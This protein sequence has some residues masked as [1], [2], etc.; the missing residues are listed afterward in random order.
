MLTHFLRYERH[1]LNAVKLLEEQLELKKRNRHFATLS[2]SYYE[3]TF[4]QSRAVL[5]SKEYFD[6]RIGS[7]L[8]YALEEEFSLIP[9][10]IP[11]GH[12]GLRNYK[13]FTLPM[14]LLYY[15]VSLYLVDLA[16]DFVDSCLADANGHIV[17]FYG[18]SL[19]YNG[20]TLVLNH[21]N[22][23]YRPHYLEFKKRLKGAAKSYTDNNGV[24]I[25]FDV[26][27]YYDEIS[28]PFLLLKLERSLTKRTRTRKSVVNPKTWTGR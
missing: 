15:A 8:F 5:I 20:D 4:A 17:P 10:T 25:K 12:I 24:V 27:N 6:Q 23:W 22:L 16:Q 9:Y 13:F 21:N 19:R 11:K 28:I 1:W 18:G 7:N 14:R 2:M 3:R 26:Q